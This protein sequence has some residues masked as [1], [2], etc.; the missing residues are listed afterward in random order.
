MNERRTFTNQHT[1]YVSARSK[2]ELDKTFCHAEDAAREQKN[3]VTKIKARRQ[4]TK[5]ETTKSYLN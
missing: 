1:R 3:C 5:K 4:K 2:E